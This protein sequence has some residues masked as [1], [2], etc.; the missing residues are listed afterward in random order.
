MEDGSS[1]FIAH[2]PSLSHPDV[3]I[4]SALVHYHQRSIVAPSSPIVLT[5]LEHIP[6]ET[7]VARPTWHLTCFHFNLKRALCT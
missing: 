2:P 1:F 5:P 7:F 4:G 6:G 3:T